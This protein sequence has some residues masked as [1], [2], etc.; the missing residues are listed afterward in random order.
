[1]R[2]PTLETPYHFIAMA[3]RQPPHALCQLLRSRSSRIL[4]EYTDTVDVWVDHALALAPTAEL[5]AA[6]TVAGDSVNRGGS[7][8]YP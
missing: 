1:M 2:T 7:M 8:A 5:A 6:A 3:V 4:R